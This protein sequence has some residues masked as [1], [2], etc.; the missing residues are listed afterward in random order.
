[1][2]GTSQG[3]TKLARFSKGSTEGERKRGGRMIIVKQWEAGDVLT[4][5]TDIT[6]DLRNAYAALKKECNSLAHDVARTILAEILE[7]E[8]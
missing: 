8:P 1:M 5:D 2:C 7:V 3:F 4:P 6:P